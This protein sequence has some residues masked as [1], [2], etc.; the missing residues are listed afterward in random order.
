MKATCRG[1]GQA[2]NCF[3]GHIRDLAAVSEIEK[4]LGYFQR[5]ANPNIKSKI[6]IS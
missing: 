1:A 6:K 4:R 3:G 2:L 5:L